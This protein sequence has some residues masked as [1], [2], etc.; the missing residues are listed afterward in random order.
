MNG[1]LVSQLP[2]IMTDDDLIHAFARAAEEIGD[3]FRRRTD[4]IEHQ[5]DAHLAS[6]AMRAYLAGWLGFPLDEHEGAEPNAAVLSAVGRSLRTRGTAVGLRQLL[7]VLTGGSVEVEDPGGVYGP[8]DQ[9]PPYDPVVRIRLTQVGPR[10]RARLTAILDREL[11]VGVSVAVS[12]P[13]GSAE[14]Q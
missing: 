11:P 6:P 4:G 9:A 14:E 2:S 5:L 13:P 12:W 8:G 7:E 1:W 3:S 10:G